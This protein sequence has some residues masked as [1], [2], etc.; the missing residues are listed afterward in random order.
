MIDNEWIDDLFYENEDKIVNLI[1]NIKPNKRTLI[2]G[3][4][5]MKYSNEEISVLF[6]LLTKKGI[7]SNAEQHNIDAAMEYLF[8]GGYLHI[9]PDNTFTYG[10]TVT[11]FIRVNG[12]ES[13]DESDVFFL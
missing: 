7:I 9:R 1:L 10:D 8:N 5:N 12:E 6:E 13:Y 11:T 2:F 4:K 3:R